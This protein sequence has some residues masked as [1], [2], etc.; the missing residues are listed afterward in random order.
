MALPKWNDPT[1]RAGTRIRTALWLIS[2]VGVG[3]SFT[4]EQHRA[5][6]SGVAQADRRMRDLRDYA[7]VDI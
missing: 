2:E 4:K 1:L 5:A 3:N 6:F 7:S